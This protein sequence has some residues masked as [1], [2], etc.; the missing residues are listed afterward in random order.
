[1]FTWIMYGA[2]L[3]SSLS[4]RFP[5]LVLVNVVYDV[6]F[7]LHS[8]PVLVFFFSHSFFSLPFPLFL[9]SLFFCSLRT[10]MQLLRAEVNALETLFALGNPHVTL[11]EDP[12]VLL[13]GVALV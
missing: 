7:I 2:V 10:H 4:S 5:P 11:L 1:M 12:E 13:L 9:S 3:T 6:V 8:A